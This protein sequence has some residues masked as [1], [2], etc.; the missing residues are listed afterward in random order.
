MKRYQPT[1]EP[2][3]GEEAGLCIASIGN[4]PFI[5]TGKSAPRTIFTTKRIRRAKF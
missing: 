1:P 2:P 3:A 5:E 4:T